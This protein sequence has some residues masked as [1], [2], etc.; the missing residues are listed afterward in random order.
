M[1]NLFFLIFIF[2][3]FKMYDLYCMENELD[4]VHGELFTVVYTYDKDGHDRSFNIDALPVNQPM[5]DL[6]KCIVLKLKQNNFD[7][8]YPAKFIFRIVDAENITNINPN[9]FVQEIAKKKEVFEVIVKNNGGEIDKV[10]GY[11]EGQYLFKKEIGLTFKEFGE[12]IDNSN[13]MT[14]KSFGV[15]SN[16]L[17]TLFIK[18]D[19]SCCGDFCHVCSNWCEGCCCTLYACCC[20][21]YEFVVDYFVKKSTK[22]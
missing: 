22:R 3:A 13:Y 6:I 10:V 11:S 7:I 19:I 12:V 2:N 9:Q 4:D 16:G 8:K 5:K 21:Q 20:C 18:Q 14:F 1:K 15:G 17:V